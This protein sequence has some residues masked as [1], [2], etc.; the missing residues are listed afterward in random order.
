MCSRQG[1]IQV[2]RDLKLIT[3]MEVLFKGK[4]TKLNTK[5]DTGTQKGNPEA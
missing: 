4:N 5:L 3:I 2:L 1:Q